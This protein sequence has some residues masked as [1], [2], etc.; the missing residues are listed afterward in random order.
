MTLRVHVFVLLALGAVLL[1]AGDATAQMGYHQ[2]RH[3]HVNE[4]HLNP[5]QIS[6]LDQTL[7]YKVPDGFYWVNGDN[8]TWGYQGSNEALGSIFK[9]NDPRR[10]AAARQPQQQQQQQ[11]QRQKSSGSG[12]QQPYKRPYISNDTGTGSAV[13]NRNK[14]GCSYVSAGGT[15]MRVCD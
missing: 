2:N 11:Q 5:Q 1:P 14:G 4:A 8:G 3:I 7:G 15:T 13:I 10:A 12:A 6:N 9:A